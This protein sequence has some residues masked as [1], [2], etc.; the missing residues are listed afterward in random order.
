MLFAEQ[1]SRRKKISFQE[2][3]ESYLKGTKLLQGAL[4]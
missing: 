2:L 3:D 1:Q 4:C